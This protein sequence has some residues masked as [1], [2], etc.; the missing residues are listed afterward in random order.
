[1]LAFRFQPKEMIERRDAVHRAGREL[2]RAGNVDKKI[3]LEKSE[4]SLRGMEDF[5]ECAAA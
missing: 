2:E 1:M 3:V 5:D 4:Y